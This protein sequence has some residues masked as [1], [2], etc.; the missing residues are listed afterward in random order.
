MALAFI[1][2]LLAQTLPLAGD[3][4][5]EDTFIRM[6]QREV[7]LR[8]QMTELLQE[9]EQSDRDH[10]RTGMLALLP[11]LKIMSGLCVFGLMFWLIWK[12]EKKLWEDQDNSDEESS[13]NEQHQQEEQQPAQQ[14]VEEDK[15]SFFFPEIFRPVQEQT[16]NFDYVFFL[17]FDLIWYAEYFTIGTFYPKAHLPIG[18]GTSNEGW[19]FTEEENV[20]YLFVAL[21]A[22]PG[23]VF[24]PELDT[25]GEL[26]VRN[27]R[28]H[29]E[30]ECT[31]GREEE[32][33][34]LCFVHTPED[35]LGDQ[36]PST[37]QNLCTGSYLDVKKTACWFMVL[38]RLV[39]KC[40][41]ESA[42]Y[43]MNVTL[44]RRS[45]RIQLEDPYRSL[46]VIDVIFG[47]Q[48][49]NTD[50]FLSS[51]ESE[52]SSIPS[53]TWPQTCAVAEA[54][55]FEHIDAHAGQDSF[56]LECLKVCA[57]ILEG[58]NFSPYELKTVL[59]HLLTAI[60]VE[61][62]SRRYFVQRTEDILRYLQCC[63]EEKRLDHFL[64]GN[65]EV[66]AEIIL[67]WEFRVSV[68]PNL[69][70]RLAQDPD[71]HE[72]ALYEMEMLQDRLRTLL[73]YGK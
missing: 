46:S 22:P 3:E 20:F 8:E 17:L 36:R 19:Q 31:C 18:V 35:T 65:E 10:S 70:Q 27:S 66:P 23:H 47:V 52:I 50:I 25:A 2:A 60:P 26:P 13:S 9:V 51:Q 59:M 5:H 34:M 68:P 14:S 32:L 15:Q 12:I 6:R 71:R 11:S 73:I 72:Q 7:Y 41:P 57:Y 4:F 55:F 40:M 61:C 49:G 29:V 24:Q 69:F 48:Q 67:P 1:F 64:I 33:N 44:T 38:F 43:R 39:W 53:T 30:L 58:Y 37:L 54:K 62:W 21:T 56:H 63:V 28:I 16:A 45:F 42:E